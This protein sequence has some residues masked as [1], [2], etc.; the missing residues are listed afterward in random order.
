MCGIGISDA[1]E[2]IQI[3]GS[4]VGF[5]HHSGRDSRPPDVMYVSD[6][7]T[8]KFTL[9]SLSYKTNTHK[10]HHCNGDP[11]IAL[12]SLSICLSLPS[13]KWEGACPQ[14]RFSS[15]LELRSRH[16]KGREALGLPLLV[17]WMKRLTWLMNGNSVDIKLSE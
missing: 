16:P 11:L 15:S 5:S 3:L 2:A 9:K 10:N 6:F 4:K 12:L 13:C 7:V 17:V 8:T 1:Q 14:R